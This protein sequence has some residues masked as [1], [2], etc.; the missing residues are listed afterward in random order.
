MFK[1]SIQENISFWDSKIPEKHIIQSAR[2]AAI[3]DVV[4][5]RTNAYDSM[6]LERGTNFSG[7]QRQ[8]LEIAR[9]LALNPTILIM[10]EATSALDPKSEKIVM[11]N[12]K[13]RGCTCL[14]VAHRLSTI[15]DCD[16]IIMMEFGKIVERGTH[17]EL[18]NMN[19]SYAKLIDSK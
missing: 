19:G 8:R 17:Q 3:H 1:G 9:A 18:L 4:A 14:I 15:I 6:V 16:E 10:D 7:G 12:I 2:D 13:K 5:A 11:D